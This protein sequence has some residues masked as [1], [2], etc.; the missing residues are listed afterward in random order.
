MADAL[1]KK[2][3]ETSPEIRDLFDGV[4]LAN[5]R[6]MLVGS[7]HY[8]VMNYERAGVLKRTLTRLGERHAEYGTKPEHYPVFEDCLIHAMTQV[9]GSYW[10]PE[11]ENLWRKACRDVSAIMMAGQTGDLDGL[12]AEAG[13]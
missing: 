2:L 8:I 11:I 13:P 6:R 1:Y 4:D 3:F 12:E 7:L 5:Q 9:A 10:D